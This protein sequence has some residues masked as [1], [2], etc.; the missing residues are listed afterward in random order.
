MAGF[1]VS[2]SGDI[3]AGRRRPTFAVADVLGGEQ[4]GA[5]DVGHAS[6]RPGETAAFC[7]EWGGAPFAAVAGVRG[8]GVYTYGA[9]G[10]FAQVR[11]RESSQTLR[12][13]DIF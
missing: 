2:A 13:G 3:A 7:G 4:C 12:R 8:R 1:T 11:I 10:S 6:G 9:W 5:H